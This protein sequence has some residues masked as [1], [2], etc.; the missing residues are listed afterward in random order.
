ML[1]KLLQIIHSGHVRGVK[2]L[3][4]QLDVSEALLEGMV[5][6]L[7]RMGYLRPVEADCLAAC[8]GCPESA[9]CK[10]VGSGRLWTLTED[11]ERIAQLPT[12]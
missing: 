5:D 8:N 6:Q 11:G 4:Q 2:Q 7:V 10:P 1:L 12:A 3:A 9:M